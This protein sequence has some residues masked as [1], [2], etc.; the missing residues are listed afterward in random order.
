MLLPLLDGKAFAYKAGHPESIPGWG[1]APGEGAPLQ[2][3]CLGD[4]MDGG[5][6]WL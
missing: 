5:A 4:P 6:W 2:Y 3:S 1:R